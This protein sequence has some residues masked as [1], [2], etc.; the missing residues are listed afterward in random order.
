MV[1]T[2][3]KIVI[4]GPPDTPKA[5]AAANDPGISTTEEAYS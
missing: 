1:T 2:N 3:P 5:T 4:P